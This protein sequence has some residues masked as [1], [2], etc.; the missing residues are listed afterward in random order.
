MKRAKSLFFRNE[1]PTEEQLMAEIDEHFT[2]LSL[3]LKDFTV[4]DFIAA[5]KIFLAPVIRKALQRTKA[6]RSLW[7]ATKGRQC[8]A[9]QK[10]KAALFIAA[11]LMEKN[12]QLRLPR[13]LTQLANAVTKELKRQGANPPSTRTLRRWLAE[14]RSKK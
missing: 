3:S 1:E 12:P 13:K 10:K 2:S 8:K 6:D 11:R 9:E 7:G 5:A 4:A 14:S